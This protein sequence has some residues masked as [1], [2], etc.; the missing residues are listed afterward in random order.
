MSPGSPSPS[1]S[2]SLLAVS[3]HISTT[4]FRRAVAASFSLFSTPHPTPPLPPPHALVSP[5]LAP[6]AGGVAIGHLCHCRRLLPLYC[7]P[8]PASARARL[9]CT[10]AGGVRGRITVGRLR[11]RLLPI[12]CSPYPA[13]AAFSLSTD[14]TLGRQTQHDQQIAQSGRLVWLRGPVPGL[15]HLVGAASSRW[16]RWMV[17]G[18]SVSALLLPFYASHLLLSSGTPI[19]LSSS[20]KYV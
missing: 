5:M 20:I 18:A 14:Q 3:T 15:G 4:S 8:Y 11:H 6:R 7:S 10:C 12:H 2:P 1:P 17:M 13:V 19:I 16:E 9:R